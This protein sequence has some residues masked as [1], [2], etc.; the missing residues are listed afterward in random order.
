MLPATDCDQTV[1][2]VYAT[3]QL[4]VK[5]SGVSI[6]PYSKIDL[7]LHKSVYFSL[8][9]KGQEAMKSIT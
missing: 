5:S 7:K 4:T 1:H 2:Y 9:G 3:W 8:D 6:Y